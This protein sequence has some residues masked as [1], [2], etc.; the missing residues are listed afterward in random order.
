[1]RS[2]LFITHVFNKKFIMINLDC[3]NILKIKSLLNFFN[4]SNIF[5]I[6]IESGCK[7]CK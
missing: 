5:L 4:I 3:N 1:M 7:V 6:M 2:Y